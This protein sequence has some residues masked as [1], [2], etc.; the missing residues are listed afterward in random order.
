M[1]SPVVAGHDRSPLHPMPG[2]SWWQQDNS[3]RNAFQEISTN[4]FVVKLKIGTIAVQAD[5]HRRQVH[6]C[7]DNNNP[8]N[9]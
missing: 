1:N 4:Y 2:L 7:F 9:V 3:F 8:D 6:S 5:R